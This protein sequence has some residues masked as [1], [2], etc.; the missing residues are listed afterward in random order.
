MSVASP[1]LCERTPHRPTSRPPAEREPL[2]SDLS[3]W[4]RTVTVPPL[5]P[6]QAWGADRAERVRLAALGGMA[7]ALL[8]A[9]DHELERQGVNVWPA[10]VAAWLGGP[11]PPH[12]LR[13]R[14]LQSLEDDDDVLADLYLRCVSPVGRRPLGTFFTPPALA[15]HMV[16]HI[17]QMLPSAPRTVIDPGA[18]VGAFTRL[19]TAQWPEANHVAVDVNL[20]TLGL[21]IVRCHLQGRAV[22]H[23]D[24]WGARG[25]L[26]GH[27]ELGIAK[28][29]WSRQTSS[30]VTP[31]LQDFLEW[32]ACDYSRTSAP[33]LIL[34]NP[35]YVRHQAIPSEQREAARH[36]A[37]SLVHSKLAGLST[38]F[39]AASL[40]SLS[41]EDSLCLVL[42]S[43]WTEAHYGRGLREHLWTLH[44]RRV[45]LHTFPD[46]EV[47]LFPGAAVGAVILFVGPVAETAQPFI[48]ARTRLGAEGVSIVDS[49]QSDRSRSL[50]ATFTLEALRAPAADNHHSRATPALLH[51]YQL[52]DVARV[53]RGVATGANA[54]F[55][56]KDEVAEG[57]PPSMRLRAISRLRTLE[58]PVLDRSVWNKLAADGARCWLLK[59]PACSAL[60]DLPPAI[61][62]YLTQ[63]IEAVPG[64]LARE[65]VRRRHPWWVLE[66]VEAP[67]ILVS[68]MTK[69]EHRVVMNAVGAVP[70]NTL[71][72]VYV[73][74]P[75]VSVRAV[76]D[77]LRSSQGQA[78][79][80]AASRSQGAGLRK[81]EPRALSSLMLPKDL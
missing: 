12:E 68:P 81:L 54:V 38:Y 11:H 36:A 2:L 61:G 20:A 34:G 48:S 66:R 28:D 77:W 19:T 53:R 70:T 41:P 57:F 22:S 16:S 67:S 37:G 31:R 26:N 21:L 62:A 52:G 63:Q 7:A 29:Y 51:A 44:R 64:L 10:E 9:S 39:T 32:L 76:T 60:T 78:A 75:G 42:P 50:P 6:E 74:E 18:G 45:E 14:L 59:L 40:A 73:D 17:Q 65:L 1:D 55:L 27:A 23:T 4:L 25:D 30:I 58:T 49:R 24:A 80:R 56:L 15:G 79:M 35:P 3:A 8:Q 46:D 47:R 33:R 13:D 43:N 69:T 71:Y 72:G 5:A